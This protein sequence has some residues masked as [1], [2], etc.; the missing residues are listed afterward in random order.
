MASAA[1]QLYCRAARWTEQGHEAAGWKP[2]SQSE[3]FKVED[4][5]R[6]P[7]EVPNLRNLFNGTFY[8]VPVASG[9]VDI[10][11]AWLKCK[12]VLPQ[13]EGEHEPPVNVRIPIQEV[14]GEV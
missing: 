1:C 14:R 13:I 7:R 10:E 6:S 3:S 5:K 2:R 9:Q 11:A 8:R 4:R 12:P